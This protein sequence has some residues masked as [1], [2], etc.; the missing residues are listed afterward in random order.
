[1]LKCIISLLLL[2]LSI[3]AIHNNTQAQN[4]KADTL[5]IKGANDEI[6]SN[7]YSYFEDKTNEAGI[8]EILQLL[9][10]QQFINK[11]KGKHEFNSRY[12]HGTYWFALPVKN[13]TTYTLPL[14]WSFYQNNLGY[15]LYDITDTA[16]PVFMD[17]VLS[18][19][20]LSKRK[21]KLRGSSFQI[22]L[23][24]NT[25]K[26][27]L[28]KVFI[29]NSEGLYLPTDLT[30]TEDAYLW[31]IDNAFLM[32]SY[33]GYFTLICLFNIF[34]WLFLKAKIHLW[35]SLYVFMII[36]YS[37]TENMYDVLYFP[38][39]L[40]PS[41][42]KL[43]KMFFLS[44][45]L[46]F[47]ITVFQIFS[48]QQ[49]SFPKYYKL[50]NYFKIAILTTCILLLFNSFLFSG[51]SFLLTSLR[52]IMDVVFYTGLVT[53]I[54]N[55]IYGVYKKHKLIIAYLM[56]I[57]F[58][59]IAYLDLAFVSILKIR[60]MYFRPGN[61]LIGLGIEIT[62]L[63]A[64]FIINI[65][66]DQKRNYLLLQQK[67]DENINLTQNIIT[68]QEQ[69]RKRIAEDLHDDIGATLSAL[70]L[71]ISNIPE[72]ILSGSK[73]LQ[74]FYATSLSLALK[75][76]TDVRGISHDLL[77]K[78]FAELGLFTI[79]Q[80]RIDELN[81]ANVTHFTIITDG[82]ENTLTNIYSITIYRIINEIISNVVHH[83]QAQKAFIQ[84]LVNCNQLQIIAEDD[85]IGIGEVKTKNGIGM[86]NVS[87]RVTFLKGTLNIDSNKKGT[88]I[89][90][91]IPI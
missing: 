54:T 24:A 85:G 57:I 25:F 86:K 2:L 71:H 79:L 64:F 27:L 76:A 47:G 62:L 4:I 8:G 75:A 18:S 34:L 23:P 16:H 88:T 56:A 36:L 45:S 35:H 3:V 39:W 60:L 73:V 17:S 90:I 21:I 32:G 38:D 61:V 83:S 87:S 68:I 19:W 72:Q 46:F 43:P 51:Q 1:M 31:E 80:N 37:L 65:S 82:E 74:Q 7:Y 78:D 14:L 84:I 12:T 69:E 28:V 42:N 29:L 44:F 66:N 9:K 15:V 59:V 58:L 10:Q 67:N 30:T 55:I 26:L 40:Y 91:D 11:T 77:P 48:K 33:M 20:P 6:L 70:H 5:K 52:I 89:I 13:D 50:F 49:L 22:N 63:T 41:F 81:A 53:L